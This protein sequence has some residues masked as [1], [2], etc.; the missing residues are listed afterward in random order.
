MNTIFVW[1]VRHPSAKKKL[2]T[3]QNSKGEA[4]VN[5]SCMGSDFLAWK[6]N[7][8]SQQMY[9][10][11]AEYPL[12]ADR[13][14]PFQQNHLHYICSVSTQQMKTQ[15]TTWRNASCAN[16]NVCVKELQCVKTKCAADRE[17]EINKKNNLVWTTDRLPF[18]LRTPSSSTYFWAQFQAPLAFDAET[19]MLARQSAYENRKASNTVHFL[20]AVEWYVEHTEDNDGHPKQRIGGIIS[21]SFEWRVSC[22]WGRNAIFCLVCRY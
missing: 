19:A 9:E 12:V 21:C 13:F 2:Q 15:S 3:N 4:R 8:I 17:I 1:F 5:Q 7:H 14:V 6:Y 22:K 11:V 20:S 16:C 18:S 10:I